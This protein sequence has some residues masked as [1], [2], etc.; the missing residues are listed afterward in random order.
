MSAS[1]AREERRHREIIE[2]AVR[3]FARKGYQD[4]GVA[5]IA[6]ELGIGH[7]TFYRYFQ[8]KHDVAAQV[9]DRVVERIAEALGNE[10]PADSDTLDEYR[11]QVERICGRVFDLI[12][13]YPD[14][15][16]FF[17]RESLVVDADRLAA[18]MDGFAAFAARFIANGV[19]RGFVRQDVD[20]E[21][22]AQALVG[23]I[24]EGTRRALGSQQPVEARQR[25]VAAG[26]A[27]MFEGIAAH[28]ASARLGRVRAE[29]P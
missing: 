12:D 15:M 29:D 11:D 18:A 2:A 26:T 20:V 8:S 13:E 28:P 4:A 10:D 27:L 5:D 6:A 1:P 7:G 23:I 14:L 19:R 24:S 3:V 22:T 25:W 21:I 16:R 17:H 9:A